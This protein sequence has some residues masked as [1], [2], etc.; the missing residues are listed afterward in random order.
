LQHLAAAAAGTQAGV[1]HETYT[2]DDRD[3]LTSKTDTLGNTTQYI[4][5]AA[6]IIRDQPSDIIDAQGNRTSFVF[7]ER[8]R[9][10][11]KIDAKHQ[12]VAFAYNERGDRIAITDPSGKTSSFQFDGNRR[13]IAKSVPSSEGARGGRMLAVNAVSQYLYD[14]DGRLLLEKKLGVDNSIATT[15]YSY[16]PLDRLIEKVEARVNARG[17]QTTEDDSTYAYQP[18]LD[19]TLLYTANNEVE[20]LGF[21]YQP[22]PPFKP[23]GYGAFATDQRNPLHLIQGFYVISRDVTGEI[24]NIKDGN[25]KT[26]FSATHDPAGRLLSMESG[27]LFGSTNA[28]LQALGRGA[29]SL[30]TQL[31]YDSFGRIQVVQH[32][33][34]LSGSFDYD[35]DGR[36][37]DISWSQAEGKFGRDIPFT[38]EHLTYDAVGNIIENDRPFGR[39]R[40]GYDPTYQLVSAHLDGFRQEDRDDSRRANELLN[41]EFTYDESGNRVRDSLL[42]NAAFVD[43]QIASYGD[44]RYLADRAGLG[45]LAYEIDKEGKLK[46]Y[47]YRVDGKLSGFSLGKKEWNERHERHDRYLGSARYYFDALGRRVAKITSQGDYAYVHLADQDRILLAKSSSESSLTLYLD[48][49]GVDQHLGQVSL[50][51]AQGYATDHLGSVLNTPMAGELHTFGSFGETLAEHAEIGLE[52]VVYGFAGREWDSESGLYYNRAREYSSSTGRFLTQDPIGLSGGDFNLYRY[53]GNNSLVLT[54]PNGKC[55]LCIVVAGG[56]LAGAIINVAIAY[57]SGN[58]NAGNVVATAAIGAI[59]GSVIVL[60]SGALGAAA[61]ATSAAELLTI[62]VGSQGIAATLA[63]AATDLGLTALT[64]PPPAGVTAGNIA[65]GLSGPSCSL[66]G[67]VAGQPSD[68]S[69]NSS[70]PAAP[71]DTSGSPGGP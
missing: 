66:N 14:A 10:I 19:A 25:G 41:R 37:M 15:S 34:G 56:A 40:Y 27:D 69:G 42:G 23:M 26:L 2:W 55:P 48:G 45:N 54:D 20:K 18:Q 4:Y 50:R 16:N 57:R 39:L 71:T 29:P 47:E 6:P 64:N 7:D 43:N 12:V 21:F 28:I 31:S 68:A 65:T 63:G 60:S 53:V 70:G 52:P 24:Q 17:E 59:S 46:S 32:S 62:E 1:L 11:Q 35:G 5:S 61:T 22:A 49:Q 9:L 58:L 38:S 51:A 36:V 30:K 8:G 13:L 44:T 3:R 33:T 67:Q